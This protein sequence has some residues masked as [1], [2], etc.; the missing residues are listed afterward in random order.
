[1]KTALDDFDRQVRRDIKSL[2]EQ[3]KAKNQTR[4]KNAAD[5]GVS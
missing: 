4:Q 5:P 2:D 1:M 3:I